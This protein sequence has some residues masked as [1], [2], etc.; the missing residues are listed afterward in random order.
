[1]DEYR[2]HRLAPRRLGPTLTPGSLVLLA[3]LALGASALLLTHLTQSYL[4]NDEGSTATIARTILHHGVPMGYDGENS[5]S[6]EEGRDVTAGGIYRFQPWLQFYAAAASFA[7]LGESTFSA[8]L[9]FALFGIATI[10][11]TY[12]LAWETWKNRAAAVA[13]SSILALSV[14]FLLLAGQCRYYSMS[15]FFAALALWSY[16]RLLEGR[17]GAAV[18]F[19]LA[20]LALLHTM[21]GHG[22]AL[23]VALGLHAVLWHRDR[24]RVVLAIAGGIAVANFPWLLWMSSS[25]FNNFA[26]LKVCASAWSFVLQLVLYAPHPVFLVAWAVLARK[27]RKRTP[28]AGPGSPFETGTRLLLIVVAVAVPLLAVFAERPYFR[29]LAIFLPLGS[30]IAGKVV[31]ETWRSSRVWACVVVAAWLVTGLL[32]L[33]FHEMTQEYKGPVRGIVTY[34]NEHA[35]PGDTVA[36]TYED[37]PIKFYTKLRVVGGY[38]GDDPAL[39]KQA[40]WVIPRKY[41][42]PGVEKYY[43]Q[44]IASGQFK[45]IELAD[46]RDTGFENRESPYEHN[47]ATPAGARPTVIYERIAP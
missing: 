39:V 29:Y 44:E 25:H 3:I 41:G 16:L 37:L 14:P 10:L 23:L 43:R 18:V 13:A 30:V 40:R 9:P 6:A 1:M 33:Y 28:E 45:K 46:Y 11:V 34:L 36:I 24:A 22:I 20:G 4:W 15:S 32:P 35:H 17:K 31:T 7:V 27:A 2:P 19:A 5:L 8:R 38:T 42:V 26:P 12:F 47:F 21:H